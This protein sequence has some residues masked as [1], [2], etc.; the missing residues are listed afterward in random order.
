MSLRPGRQE[1]LRH[2]NAGQTRKRRARSVVPDVAGAEVQGRDY[3][4]ACWYSSTTSPSAM[5]AAMRS[6]QVTQ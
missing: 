6:W 1:C 3:R 2:N 5:R 4:S